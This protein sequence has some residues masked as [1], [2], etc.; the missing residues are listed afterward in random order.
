MTRF[1][2]KA[3]TTMAGGAG[4]LLGVLVLGGCAGSTPAARPADF[5]VHAIDQQVDLHWRIERGGS[6]V[7]AAGLAERRAPEVRWAM[8][9]LIGLD[10][11]GRIVSFSTPELVRWQSSLDAETF[12]LTVGPRGQEQDF[13]VRVQTFGYDSTR[14]GG[15]R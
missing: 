2:T 13:K 15:G 8:L 4:L 1:P 6:L 7:R 14:G 3:F 9:Q 12:S 10:A 5:P 11:A